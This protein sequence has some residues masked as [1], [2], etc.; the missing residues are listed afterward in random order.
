MQVSFINNTSGASA[1]ATYQWDFG[2]GNTS[3]KKNPGAVFYIEQAYI[4]TLTVKDGSQTSVKTKTISVSRKPV[5]DFSQTAIRGCLPLTVTFNSSSV[6][7]DGSLGSYYWDFGDG[8]TQQT[9]TAQISH[10]YFVPQTA[11]VTL[12]AGNSN[13]C[14]NTITKKDLITI[15]PRIQ[16]G[17][18]AEQT[19]YCQVTDVVRFANSS[20]GPGVLSY[21]WDFGDGTT[22]I[23]PVPAHTYTKKGFYTVTLTATSSEGCSALQTQTLNIANFT[24]TFEPA[25]LACVNN[26]LTLN[27][28]SN[29]A[30][31][32]STWL[33]DGRD[34]YNS[35]G[36]GPIAPYFSTAGNHTVQLTNTFGNCQ[37][38]VIKQIDVTPSLDLQGFVA[39]V[40]ALCGSPV[41][42]K[43]KDTTAGA[44]K[45][46]WKFNSYSN[47]PTSTLATPSYTYLTDDLYTVTLT[48]SNAAGCT[49]TISKPVY[50][51]RPLVGIFATDVAANTACESLTKSFTARSTEVITK[52]AWNFGDGTTSTD[53]DPVH[54]FNKPG[55]YTVKLT[56][57]T[58]NGC[59]GTVSYNNLITIQRK[60][61]ADFTGPVSVCGNTAVTFNSTSTGDINNI[62]W[63]FGDGNPGYGFYNTHQFSSEGSYTI[64]FIALNAGCSDTIVKKDYIR[65]TPPFP[66]IAG[67]SNTCD[68]NRGT[69][70]F[71]DGSG[72]T[73]S[74]KW[75]FGD[76]TTLNYTTA[77]AQVKHEYA[78]SGLYTVVLTNTYG[79]CTLTNSAAVYV[80][81]KQKPQLTVQPQ[82]I[83]VNSSLAIEL[84]NLIIPKVPY[85]YDQTNLYSPYSFNLEHSDGTPLNAY[86]SGYNSTLPW[87][88][89]LTAFT[90]GLQDIRVL[91]TSN[92]YFGC[93]DTSN[94]VPLSIKGP[95]PEFNIVTVNTCFRNPVEFQDV[96]KASVNSNIVKWDWD[97]GDGII[98]SKTAG[99][100][101]SHIYKEPGS[102]YVTLTVTETGGCM[103][104]TP[105]YAHVVEV[106]GP[107]AAFATSGTNVALN[108]TVSFYNYSNNYNSNS[109]SYRWDFGDGSQSTDF[110]PNHTYPVAGNYL[111]KLIALNTTTQCG[112]TASQVIIVKNFNFAFAMNA[113][114]I[115]NEGHCAPA[116]VNFTNTSANYTRIT[117]DFGDG[118]TLNDQNYPSHIYKDAGTYIVTLLV[119]GN[120]GLTGTYKDTIKIN[121]S[122]ATIKTNLNEGCTGLE[123]KLNAPVHINTASY[124]WD[125]GDGNVIGSN[126]SFAVNKYLSAGTY[127][128]SLIAVDDHGCSFSMP[129]PGEIVI[130]PE[131]VIKINPGN[132]VLCKGGTVQLTASGAASYSWSPA[133]ELNNNG[134]PS[135]L[136]SPAATTTY[137]VKGTDDKG[138]TGSGAVTVTVA[139]PFII[140]T[141]PDAAICSGNNIQL[142]TTGATSYQWINE[143]TGLNNPKIGNPSASPA[144]TTR[145]TVVGYDEYQCFT[146]TATVT[147]T[148]N[149]LPVIEAGPDIEAIIGSDIRLAPV[150]SSDVIN[151]SWSPADYLSCTDCASPVSRPRSPI[152]YTIT[153]YNQFHCMASGHLKVNVVCAGGQIYIPG[154]FSPNNDGK[155]DRFIILGNG[156]R[157]VKSLRI[158]NRWG[159]I[160]FTRR[161]FYPDDATAAWDGTY[162][163]FSA[164]AGIYVYV[165]EMECNANEAFTRKGTVTLI[166]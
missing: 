89:T 57:T 129:L 72:Q 140:Q 40:T 12:S 95:V 112:D 5:A 36:N 147:V 117:W 164:P 120:N 149:P 126:D 152:D 136:A 153:V 44:V 61:V 17:F 56:Y 48:V 28:T 88:A 98:V 80:L 71:T 24:S 59:T 22:S 43:F 115:G 49:N 37:E 50:I 116:I 128:P 145:Y 113:V 81:L 83:C 66:K 63:D 41:T 30:P 137:S 105:Y 158:Y 51:S 93:R 33:V 8:T 25:T 39:D 159:E 18:S 75:D 122:T 103:A 125:F 97:F 91:T 156:V 19:I 138:C 130:H 53:T 31:D 151:W 100:N 38:S 34:I 111:V 47:S 9:G 92:P 96:S 85:P 163:G 86:I 155:N 13:G 82:S 23:L 161:D 14:T 146:D 58:A 20:T 6:A 94:I 16:A 141:I 131:P 52:Y 7:G 55:S 32:F 2:N 157:I 74:W 90:P 11:S 68:G 162:K 99:G 67:I 27:N 62:I 165:A 29:P 79:G 60:I 166:R 70:T 102:Y 45:W 118:F 73:D 133:D 109:T 84:S 119:Y 54:V 10:T 144:A 114:F 26:N 107:K 142:T 123:V 21:Q 65:V 110:S 132:P 46:L 15:L 101:V 121:S 1:G 127:R 87:K 139:Q 77:T 135:T 108:T 3:I 78:K 76:G 64:T 150:V 42:V 154:A 104:S 35:Y 134:S 124:F 143:T 160:I 106:S 69:V 4:I 148:I